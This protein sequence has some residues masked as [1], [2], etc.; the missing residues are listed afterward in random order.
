MCFEAIHALIM[1]FFMVYHYLY[2][3][4]GN[5]IH[6]WLVIMQFKKKLDTLMFLKNGYDVSL[7]LLVYLSLQSSNYQKKLWKEL[8]FHSFPYTKSTVIN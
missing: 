4:L 8:S 1:L 6:F 5:S 2:N 7:I 3:I